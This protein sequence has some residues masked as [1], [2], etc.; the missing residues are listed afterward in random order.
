M[1]AARVGGQRAQIILALLKSNNH[2]QGCANDNCAGHL[3]ANSKLCASSNWIAQDRET[4]VCDGSQLGHLCVLCA[5]A[6]IE[7]WTVARWPMATDTS[8]RS[9]ASTELA[10]TRCV[11]KW[12]LPLANCTALRCIATT[13]PM[14]GGGVSRAVKSEAKQ[15][16]NNPA[17]LSQCKS[18]YAMRLL[19]Y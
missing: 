4:S 8:A 18:L 1:L 5:V 13:M 12:P 17:Y 15:N 3:P 19:L 11:H 16:K 14:V 7:R 10:A 9:L 2:L 6:A